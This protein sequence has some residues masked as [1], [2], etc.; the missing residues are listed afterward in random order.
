[1]AS[2]LVWNGITSV[3]LAFKHPFTTLHLSFGRQ[4]ESRERR[5]NIFEL[6]SPKIDCRLLKK[7]FPA[8]TFP[9]LV[10][11]CVC[12]RRYSSTRG[13]DSKT[14]PFFVP[15]CFSTFFVP[16]RIFPRSG[17]ATRRPGGVIH[18]ALRR[19]L[20]AC[21]LVGTPVFHECPDALF[22]IFF[23]F[24][25]SAQRGIVA[26]RHSK[27]KRKGLATTEEMKTGVTGYYYTAFAQRYIRAL[28]H[29]VTPFSVSESVHRVCTLLHFGSPQVR[30]EGER[31]R[32]AAGSGDGYYGQRFHQLGKLE[33]E[34]SQ[35]PASYSAPSL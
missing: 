7:T 23:F 22:A 33:N 26:K 27:K 30:G 21:K 34:E 16:R 9:T 2:A 6:R 31:T 13:R 12:V 3:I 15:G 8:A 24:F 17:D 14:A 11:V 35:L 32:P 20:P 18:S 19:H 1:M 25:F 29:A 5:A 10:C 4:V 28:N